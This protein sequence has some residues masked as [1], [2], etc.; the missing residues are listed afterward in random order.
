MPELLA[1]WGIVP[2]INRH[3]RVQGW[4]AMRCTP[5]LISA[6]DNVLKSSWMSLVDGTTVFLSPQRCKLLFHLQEGQCSLCCHR[7][8]SRVN[9]M[10]FP[11]RRDGRAE[12]GPLLLQYRQ[13]KANC[14]NPAQDSRQTC[15]PWNIQTHKP[16]F[17]RCRHGNFVYK[18][19]K[20]LDVIIKAVSPPAPVVAPP[21][22]LTRRIAKIWTALLSI[23]RGW[24]LAIP[25]KS[26]GATGKAK[27]SRSIVIILGKTIDCYQ[28]IPMLVG[29]IPPV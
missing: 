29:Q 17:D 5:Y 23:A 21:L 15:L 7:C 12:E 16:C 8:Q 11:Y 19:D 10:T 24:R 18:V 13:S 9:W 22:S 1:V 27:R 28:Y 2:T 20:H 14:A 6:V 4:V 26:I 3:R 25:P